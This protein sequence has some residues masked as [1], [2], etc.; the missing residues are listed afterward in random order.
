[1]H[2]IES[3]VVISPSN[4]FFAGVCVSVHVSARKIYVL[5]QLRGYALTH[6]LPAVMLTKFLFAG[7]F[8]GCGALMVGC[9]MGVEIVISSGIHVMSPDEM[10]ALRSRLLC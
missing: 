2:G 5:G 4:M 10:V 8:C 9:H 7:H 1:M 6:F 3:G